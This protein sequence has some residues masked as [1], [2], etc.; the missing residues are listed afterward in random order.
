MFDNF[1]LLLLLGRPL[2]LPIRVRKVLE[3]M[4]VA[5]E[6][7]EELL[8]GNLVVLRR[9]DLVDLALLE[10]VFLAGQDLSEEVLVDGRLVR[11]VVLH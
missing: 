11:E 2:V 10:E 3:E 9:R 6:R 5:G 1:R 8:D 7:G 4:L